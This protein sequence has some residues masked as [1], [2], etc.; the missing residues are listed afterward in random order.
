MKSATF[1]E[2][3]HGKDHKW[4]RYTFVDDFNRVYTQLTLHPNEVDPA[5]TTDEIASLIEADLAR[6]EAAANAILMLEGKGGEASYDYSTP[7][8][9]K[10]ELIAKEDAIL[11][12]KAETEAKLAII[13]TE[14]GQ[15]DG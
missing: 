7:E 6:N 4:V 10:A 3:P 15:T 2:T 13:A 8:Q 12:V 9:A 5:K 11:A 1:E 14:K